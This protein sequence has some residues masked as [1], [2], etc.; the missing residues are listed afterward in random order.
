M[1][2]PPT[3]SAANEGAKPAYPVKSIAS[4]GMTIRQA[5][6]MAAL[7]GYMAAHANPSASCMPNPQEV[8]TKA[9]EYADA[10]LLEDAQHAAKRDG[11]EGM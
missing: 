3:N 5:Y 10:M 6:K 11:K 9:A 4:T 2:T 7:Q 8:A 1:T